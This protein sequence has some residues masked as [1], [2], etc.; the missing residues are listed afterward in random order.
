MK[1]YTLEEVRHR[2]FCDQL[3]LEFRPGNL[4][5]E[6]PMYV[7]SWRPVGG[8]ATEI[9][10]GQGDYFDPLDDRMTTSGY[11]RL[12]RFW[13]SRPTDADRLA[14][15]WPNDQTGGGQVGE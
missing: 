7:S 13:P 12:Y 6:R 2:G 5:L 1:P 15:L 4:S 8:T 14:N 9:R 3:W 11:G 10:N